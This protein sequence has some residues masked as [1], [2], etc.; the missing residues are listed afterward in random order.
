MKKISWYMH[1]L[2]RMPLAEITHRI[3]HKLLQLQDKYFYSITF[4]LPSSSV[5]NHEL[6]F[7]LTDHIRP[8]LLSQFD[9]KASPSIIALADHYLADTFDIF[10]IQITHDNGI[11]WHLD[12]KTK[13]E[14]PLHF[15]S[16]IDI[17]DG[18]SIGG[19][20]FV[21]EINRLYCLPILGMAY[22]QTK[23]KIYGEK[24]VRL[25]DDWLSANPYPMGVNWTSGIEL[26]I[27]VA[28]L[29]WTLSLLDGFSMLEDDKKNIN[30]FIQLH[31]R[32]LNRF[33]SRFSSNNN[34]A[35]AEAFG[36]FLAGVFFPHLKGALEWR[37]FGQEVLER[38]IERQIL[39]DGGSYEYTTTYLSFVIDFFLL[40]RQVCQFLA[41]DYN[42]IVNERLERSCEYIFS[43]MD[44]WGNIPNIGD[45][46]SAILVNFG[47]GN[48]ANF[49][50]ILNTGAHIFHRHE[51][52]QTTG[53]DI[54]TCFLVK[55]A[56]SNYPQTLANER[57]NILLEESGLAVIH[58]QCKGH[59]IIF[60][61]N[62]TP[63][64]MP[65]LYAH[66]HLD[67]QSFTLS[68]GGYEVFVDP[69][70]YL[71]HCGGKWRYYFRS[72]AA[73]N[74]IRIN[75]TDFTDQ[76]GPF[77]FGS[78][79]NITVH[80]IE[81]TQSGVKW[82]VSHDAYQ[83]LEQP[84]HLLR[85]MLYNSMK[86]TFSFEDTLD[87]QGKNEVEQY[88]H[89][90]PECSVSLSGNEAVITINGIQLCMLFDHRFQVTVYE[91]SHEPMAG[92]FSTSFNQLQPC[93]TLISFGSF[94]GKTVIHTKIEIIS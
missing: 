17:R 22:R 70:T 45:Q 3:E 61:G 66:G 41:L 38:E 54:K 2:S 71:Y 62:G 47:L 65:P 19:A 94:L 88:F 7:R 77:M 23:N 53:V 12:P 72:V 24:I 56:K 42:Q 15:W 60:I 46:D 34:H 49:H 83:K 1:R 55:N 11:N 81:E 92:W 84:V 78:P 69:G 32:H 28:N 50:S 8:S 13:N 79:Y 40:Y 86:G 29:V 43:I 6:L 51:F 16:S 4:P 5:L 9:T 58:S 48:H 80:N 93:S 75:A 21:W 68:I 18:E 14:W 31:G 76:P 57:K 73:H 39:A 33:P 10:G 59:E 44:S 52:F 67:A 91:G 63:L 20:K 89:L 37:N 82:Q 74:T 36:L 30:L 90:H 27:R 87:S 35:L 85:Q 64:G 26:G 25:L